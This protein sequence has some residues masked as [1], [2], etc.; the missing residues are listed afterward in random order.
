LPLSPK[1]THVQGP[2]V[3]P[4][5]LLCCQ[6]YSLF[7]GT[8]AHDGMPKFNC[9]IGNTLVVLMFGPR[10]GPCFFGSVRGNEA[11]HYQVLV[12]LEFGIIDG[13]RFVYKVLG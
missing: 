9:Y 3:W 10:L 5:Y 6:S 11:S 2:D 13:I 1:P 4:I 7:A 12:M 8:K